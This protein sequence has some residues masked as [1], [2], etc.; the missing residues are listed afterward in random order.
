MAKTDIE[1]IEKNNQI[2]SQTEKY[3]QKEKISPREKVSNTENSN[4][5]IFIYYSTTLGKNIIVNYIEQLCLLTE[6]A[7]RTCKT[8]ECFIKR[9][10]SLREYEIYK[11]LKKNNN[12]TLPEIIPPI[13]AIVQMSKYYFYIY[14]LVHQNENSK[15]PF[16]PE[17]DPVEYLYHIYT[18]ID[19]IIKLKTQ[20]QFMHMDIK[21]QNV[22][23][24]NDRLV[25]LDIE[26]SICRNSDLSWN[27]PNI[28]EKGNIDEFLYWIDCHMMQWRHKAK[29]YIDD[30]II[31]QGDRFN[32]N[33]EYGV[34]E[35]MYRHVMR[36]LAMY[37]HGI[38]KLEYTPI[39]DIYGILS[40]LP[41]IFNFDKNAKK[42]YDAI[43]KLEYKQITWKNI[44]E[45]FNV[46]M[47]ISK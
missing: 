43:S 45:I 23:W 24:Y 17:M 21:W 14:P 26:E 32:L 33:I 34:L 37:K 3:L 16:P 2:K 39:P 6:E 41:R 30:L 15:L 5:K 38:I 46:T 22:G 4:E 40:L 12:L 1:I 18:L 29:K 8:H 10:T 35:R 11:N 31:S 9:Q 36:T 25:L 7:P 20:S 44:I 47:M 13:H 28:G 19:N 27:L 42:I